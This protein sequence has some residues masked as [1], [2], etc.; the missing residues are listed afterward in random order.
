M[1]FIKLLKGFSE[2]D[3]A[4]PLCSVASNCAPS[5]GVVE[6]SALKRGRC[7]VLELRRSSWRVVP[8]VLRLRAR[9][10][11]SGNLCPTISACCTG[12]TVG[13]LVR[14]CRDVPDVLRLQTRAV[15]KGN[16]CFTVSDFCIV[17]TVISPHFLLTSSSSVLQVASLPPGIAAR[18][19]GMS[20]GYG[21]CP[22]GPITADTASPVSV[23]T[24]DTFR[25]K[26]R[27]G[28]ATGRARALLLLL[29]L[30]LLLRLRAA[31][32]GGCWCGVLEAPPGACSFNLLREAFLAKG[33]P[34]PCSFV[35]CARRALSFCSRVLNLV[36]VRIFWIDEQRT[37]VVPGVPP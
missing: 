18:L 33:C 29:L 7:G 23:E 19:A 28:E 17:F 26:G 21:P 36:C 2:G 15:T 20:H 11:S 34:V 30:L 32:L 25:P 35:V 24:R 8:G 4:L 3:A 27:R 1:H 9:A 31:P 12:F 13:A 22:G 6:A 37:P 14:L 16:W 5:A 10:V